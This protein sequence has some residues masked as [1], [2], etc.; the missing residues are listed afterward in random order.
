MRYS[1]LLVTFCALFNAFCATRAFASS[2]PYWQWR[3]PTPQGNDYNGVAYGNGRF[4][5][6]GNAGTITTSTD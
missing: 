2:E 6:V 5:A 1:L 3:N 4:V